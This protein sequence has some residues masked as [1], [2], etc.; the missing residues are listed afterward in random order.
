MRGVSNGVLVVIAPAT[1]EAYIQVGSGLRRVLTEDVTRTILD[2]D[3][4]PSVRDERVEEGALRS[5][6]AISDVLLKRYTLSPEELR[7]IDEL[8]PDPA[9]Y[10]IVALLGIL[11][12]AS[13]LLSGVNARNKTVASILA[14]V[15]VGIL[16]TFFTTIMLP[17]SALVIAPLFI[18]LA[19]VGF[20]RHI[21]V[22]NLRRDSRGRRVA[23]ATT[24]EWGA[25]FFRQQRRD[26]Y[27]D[28]RVMS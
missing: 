10:A 5:V 20:R 23:N 22:F 14:G 9:T 6:R 1:R 26:R 13:G 11:I 27:L 19:V 3:L 25:R 8:G 2:T 21:R 4:L 7:L 18:V 12:G 16:L 28:A 17:L 15:L 24:W